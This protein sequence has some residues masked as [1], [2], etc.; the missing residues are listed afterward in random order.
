M[1]TGQRSIGDIEAATRRVARNNDLK[2][3]AKLTAKKPVLQSLFLK[4]LQGGGFLL[5]CCYCFLRKIFMFSFFF[6]F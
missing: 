2:K 5:L 1:F 4:N 6:F 3:F